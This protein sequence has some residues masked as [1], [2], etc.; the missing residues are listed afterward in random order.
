MPFP[1]LCSY[2]LH[3]VNK[4]NPRGEHLLTGA[5]ECVVWV[6]VV[7]DQ[8]EWGDLTRPIIRAFLLI[9][10]VTLKAS[11]ILRVS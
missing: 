5:I 11:E 6:E 9:S 1:A 4:P 8:V 7:T 2:S 3:N 10:R